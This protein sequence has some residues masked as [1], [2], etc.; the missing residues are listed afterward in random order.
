MIFGFWFVAKKRR[1]AKVEMALLE[2]V[3][4]MKRKSDQMHVVGLKDWSS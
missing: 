2:C 1:G 4:D 3:A